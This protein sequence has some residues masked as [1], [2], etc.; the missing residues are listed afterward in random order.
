MINRL[1]L[2]KKNEDVKPEKTETNSDS[3]SLSDDT[4]S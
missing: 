3:N 1:N 2:K 4:N